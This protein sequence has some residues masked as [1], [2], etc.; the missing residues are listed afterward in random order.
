MINTQVNSYSA[1][2]I[3]ISVPDDFSI[4]SPTDVY[5]QNDNE[6][7]KR[8]M[9][10]FYLLIGDDER[11][12]TPPVRKENAV[13]PQMILIYQPE[14]NPWRWPRERIAIDDAYGESFVRWMETGIFDANREG[15]NWSE[16]PVKTNYVITR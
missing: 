9:G 2:P 8:S 16:N 7:Y 3:T 4:T 13:A 11:T 1:A 14:G 15:G 12:V 5:D 6:A 10:G